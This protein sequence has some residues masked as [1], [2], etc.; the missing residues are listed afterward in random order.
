MS[1]NQ[2]DALLGDAAI[3]YGIPLALLKAVVKVE[4][5]F[6]PNAD[7]G[8]SVGLMQVTPSTA[9]LTRA[10]LFQPS[11]NVAAG[12]AHLKKCIGRTGKWEY[13]LSEYNGGY[14][15]TLGY[16][17]PY[18]G[19]KPIRVCN[20]WKK[21]APATGRLL[22]RDC[23]P[24][25]IVTV[26]PGTLANQPYVDKVLSWYKVYSQEGVVSSRPVTPPDPTHPPTQGTMRWTALSIGVLATLL[27]F[28]SWFRGKR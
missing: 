4:S 12:A 17:T 13:G 7:S 15:P 25:Q 9:G 2:Y 10:Q 5:N 28:G 3:Q 11:I 18:V 8:S 20:A 22:D 14:R 24:G 1:D 6:N 16:G 19:S 23:I 27:G 21:D 26:Q